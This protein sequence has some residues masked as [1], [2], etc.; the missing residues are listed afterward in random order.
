MKEMALESVVV[1]ESMEPTEKDRLEI[2]LAESQCILNRVDERLNSIEKRQERIEIK[3]K[4]IEGLI[5][6]TEWKSK[7]KEQIN[8]YFA[9]G[10]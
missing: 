1:I 7:K 2:V 10:H 5:F 9:Q 3:A 6:F 8:I 4:Q